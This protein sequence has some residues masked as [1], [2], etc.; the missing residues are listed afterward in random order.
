MSDRQLSGPSMQL[1]VLNKNSLKGKVCNYLEAK[2]K[3]FEYYK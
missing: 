2:I 1:K 3:C